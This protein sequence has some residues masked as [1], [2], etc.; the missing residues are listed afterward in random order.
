MP[1]QFDRQE[2]DARLGKAQAEMGM[3]SLDALLLFKQESMYYLA[4]YDSTGFLTSQCLVLTGDGDLTL[5]TRSSL[6][7]SD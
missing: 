6:C 4:G 2:Y 1:L 3:R 7:N 5:L